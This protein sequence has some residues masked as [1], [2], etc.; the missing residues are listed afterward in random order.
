MDA[1]LAE[2]SVSR[3]AMT[4]GDMPYV[5]ALNFVHVDD[6]IYFHSAMSGRKLDLIARNPNVCME[7]DVGAELVTGNLPCQASMRYRSVIVMGRAS[8]VSDHEEKKRALAAITAKYLG[9]HGDIPDAAIARTAVIRM[10][11]LSMTGKQ[12][13][14]LS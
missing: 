3:L 2:A 4:D 9:R 5:V 11:I 8:L 12:S 1:V 14:A 13:P 7:A 10:D 6:V